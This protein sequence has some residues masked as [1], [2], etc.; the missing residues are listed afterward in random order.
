[1]G[2]LL[3]LDFFCEASSAFQGYLQLFVLFFEGEALH[4]KFLQHCAAMS[5]AFPN[6]C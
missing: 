2:K 1:M 3:V 4:K 5:A 6:E